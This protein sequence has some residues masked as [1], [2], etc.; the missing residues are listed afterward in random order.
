[1]KQYK[2]KATHQV[3]VSVLMCA[4]CVLG[5]IVRTIKCMCVCVLTHLILE[6]VNRVGTV[7]STIL[8]II[9]GT[10][11]LSNLPEGHML[12]LP[13]ATNTI[14]APHYSALFLQ[15]AGD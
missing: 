13:T 1:M 6:K 3:F 8:Q 7:L 2:T 12:N 14:R 4:Y 15:G 11:Q 10:K 9:K 5:T